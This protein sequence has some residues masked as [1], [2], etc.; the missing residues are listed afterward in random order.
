MPNTKWE[1]KYCGKIIIKT[2]NEVPLTRC[3]MGTISIKGPTLCD[4]KKIY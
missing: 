2:S 1:C 4:F 3:V